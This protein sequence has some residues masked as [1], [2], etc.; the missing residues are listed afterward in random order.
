MF[1]MKKNK[2]LTMALLVLVAFAVVACGQRAPL[3]IE[4]SQMDTLSY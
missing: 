4:K 2:I 1:D 3:K